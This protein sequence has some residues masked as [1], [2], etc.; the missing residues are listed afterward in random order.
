MSMKMLVLVNRARQ[1]SDEIIEAVEITILVADDVGISFGSCQTIFTD[2]LGMKYA[3]AKIVTKL[4]N[5]EQKQRRMVIAQ[6]MLTTF[7]DDTDFLKKVIIGDESWVYGYDNETKNQ[8]FQW[9]LP[10]EPFG[11][12]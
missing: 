1:H 3:A 4:L 2:F 7:N 9:K 11:Q 6:K 8:S 12:M 5:F 10:E